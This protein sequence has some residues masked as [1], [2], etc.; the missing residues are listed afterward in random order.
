MLGPVLILKVK[1]TICPCLLKEEER[2][3]RQAISCLTN[4]PIRFYSE[5]A[6][7]KSSVGGFVSGLFGK[8]AAANMNK[9]ISS[10]K[11]GILSIID[12]TIQGPSLYFE[13]T[14]INNLEEEEDDDTLQEEEPKRETKTISLIQIGEVAADDAFL[15]TKCCGIILY[16]KQQG[17]KSSSNNANELI[18]FDLRED[19]EGADAETRDDVLDKLFHLV[20][21]NRQRNSSGEQQE[22][23]EPKKNTVAAKIKHFAQREIELKKTK[24]EREQKK[25]KYMKESGGLKYTALAMANR[26]IT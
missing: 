2:S 11:N 15:S 6:S 7:G 10:P 24:R 8:G 22:Q 25:S 23:D 14:T 12:C 9:V 26:E 1:G 5:A 21:W 3:T 13:T 19:N 16:E 17:R 4:L 20:Q 18:R